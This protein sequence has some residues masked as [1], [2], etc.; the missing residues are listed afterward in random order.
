MPSVHSILNIGRWALF[1]SQTALQVTGNNIANVD[2]P[3]YSR[4]A[5]VFEEGISLDA[6]CGQ[7]GT[8]VYAKEVIRYFNEFIEEQ[9]NTKA[10]TQERWYTQYQALLSMD[11]LFNESMSQG[12]NSA[13]SQFWADW[14]DLS[15][16]PED[17]SAREA[18][19]GDTQNL[20]S[21]IRSTRNDIV[22]Q[23]EQ[24]DDYITQEVEEV[25]KILEEIAALN[26]QIQVHD[27]PGQNNAN[28]LY[29]NRA[30]LVRELAEKLDIDFVDSGGGDVTILTKA[31]HTLVDGSQV[32]EIKFEG[33]KTMKELAEGS[34]F[35]GEIFFDGSD[36]FEYTLEV[37]TG[38]QVS[39]ASTAAVFRVSLDG[40][41][42]WMKDDDGNDLHYSARPEGGK[43]SVGDL[44]IWFGIDGDPSTAPANQLSAGDTFTIV[45]KTGLYW[46]ENT[47]TCMNITPQIYGSGTDNQRRL[48]GG[49]L[50]GYFNFRDHY[51]GGYLEKLDAFAESMIWEVNRLHSQ[52]AGLQ[53]FNHVIGTYS[54]DLDNTALVSNSTG[55]AFG[56][57]I[58]SGS[59]M[60]YIYS[61]ST[62]ELASSASYGP[63]DFGAA[64]GIQNFDPSQHSLED[65]RDAYN[66]T[67]GNFLTADIVSGRLRIQSESGYE[68]AFGTDTT[69]LNAALG[70]NT[71]FDGSDAA[72][73]GLNVNTESDL[74]LICAGHVNGAG[75]ANPGDNTAALAIAGLQYEE[76][77]IRTAF[78]GP[79]SQTL[80]EYFNVLVG[81]VGGDTANAEF[82]YLYHKALA[83]DL[84]ARQEETAGVN[85]DEEMSNLIKFQSTYTAAAKLIQAAEDML[86]TILT[87]KS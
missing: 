37:V 61:A 32:F 83:D 68:F 60:V 11:N 40:G 77:T 79:T 14:Q 10:S 76:V 82:N 67:F 16:R 27:I 43:V 18:L 54:V 44:T 52:G 45:P 28:S 71:F 17:Y 50:A 22:R 55:L 66:R 12:I 3:G 29:D 63:L 49:S 53:N 85:L 86:Q 1:S 25:N 13:T 46:Y 24:M 84:D 41:R 64:A 58:Q 56:D 62:G 36:D 57:K 23:Q 39:N 21:A 4:Q 31:G 48:I 47:S 72:T 9:Y 30:L 35:D 51:V 38:G 33:S 19:M 74:D 34:T 42:T 81:T 5:V 6:S 80:E 2:T 73:M 20:L 8:G 75:E 69:G 15:L 26:L 59:S 70:I 65:V 7:I 78:T 87:L